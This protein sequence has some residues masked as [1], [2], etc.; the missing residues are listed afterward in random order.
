MVLPDL[1]P[2]SVNQSAR[3]GSS[4]SYS[5]VHVSIFVF[6]QL[7]SLFLIETH[8]LPTDFMVLH[9]F[10]KHCLVHISPCHRMSDLVCKIYYCYFSSLLS[11]F[12]LMHCTS[13]IACMMLE[14]S[15]TKSVMIVRPSSNRQMVQPFHLT[16]LKPALRPSIGNGRKTA[17]WLK[18]M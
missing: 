16:C 12:L 3:F 2:Q 11:Y 15:S 13:C 5:C 7:L 4:V 14:L 1:K 6:I 10:S 18:Q 8:L 17:G 9:H